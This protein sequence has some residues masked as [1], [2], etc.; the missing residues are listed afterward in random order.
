[1]TYRTIREIAATNMILGRQHLRRRCVGGPAPFGVV[2]LILRPQIR[3]GVAM[4]VEAELHRQSFG[5]VAER[6]LV[7]FAMTVRAADALGDVNAVVEIN[8]VR[9]V[10]D[11]VP[12]DRLIVDKALP[13]R[14]QK[15]GV[16]PDLGMAGHAG[17]GRRQASAGRHL[18]RSMAEAAILNPRHDVRG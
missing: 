12:D 18:H 2:D 13:H 1:M 14:R 4:T 8:I 9:Q 10:V 5:L 11:P 7:Y 17:G 15:R 3:A 6:H 16:R